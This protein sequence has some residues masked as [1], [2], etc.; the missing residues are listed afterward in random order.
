MFSPHIQH[1]TTAMDKSL[2]MGVIVSAAHYH[3]W[4]HQTRKLLFEK[5]CMK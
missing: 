4:D 2:A 3:Q 5:G 1:T